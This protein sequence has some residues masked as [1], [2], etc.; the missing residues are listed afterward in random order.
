MQQKISKL[1]TLPPHYQ[2]FIDEGEI[3]NQLKLIREYLSHE[4]IPKNNL[5]KFPFLKKFKEHVT[6][7]D[8]PLNQ[9]VKN[10]R[11]K[12]LIPFLHHQIHQIDFEN[13]QD[14]LRNI[15]CAYFSG[16]YFDFLYCFLDYLNT[17]NKNKIT[18]PSSEQKKYLIELKKLLIQFPL[19][20]WIDMN[21]ILNSLP[22][23]LKNPDWLPL[24]LAKKN[25]YI[26]F[27]TN[28]VVNGKTIKE[29]ERLY[30]ANRQLFDDFLITPLLLCQLFFFSSFGILDCAFE[31]DSNHEPVKIFQNDFL[32]FCNHLKAVRLTH[33]GAFVLN[34]TNQYQPISPSVL[35]TEVTLSEDIL[36]VTLNQPDQALQYFFS[37]IGR[38]FS[39]HHYILDEDS[40]IKSCRSAE[41]L[42][43]T[44]IRFLSYCPPTLPGIWQQFFDQLKSRINPLSNPQA[45]IVLNLKQTPQLIQVLTEDKI[46][47]SLY[48]RVEGYRIA[49]TK[50]DFPLFVERLSKKGFFIDE[51]SIMFD[52]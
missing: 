34:I 22:K 42:E 50:K 14:Y 5:Y 38:K 31:T 28:F 33:L 7:A 16:Q 18:G 27:Q 17:K 8:F 3:L 39:E 41:G 40:F 13:P 1:K 20:Q 32:K 4:K 44:I 36:L 24:G 35:S 30:L 23:G 51:K 45:M 47:K 52:L 48:L 46:L 2:L 19:M 25:I 9:E 11:L 10:L 49:I 15:F 6:L 26:N 43:K 21:S 37:K 12:L 29:Q